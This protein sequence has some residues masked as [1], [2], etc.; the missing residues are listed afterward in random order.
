MTARVDDEVGTRKQ[1]A[2]ARYLPTSRMVGL[3]LSHAGSELLVMEE[4]APFFT[5]EHGP[6]VT[7]APE[8]TWRR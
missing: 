3:G 4:L 2:I 1:A 8:T 6:Q 7:A 5:P